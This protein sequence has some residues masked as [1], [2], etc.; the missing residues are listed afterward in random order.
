MRFSCLTHLSCT[1]CAATFEPT[2]LLN[3]CPAPG[4]GGSLFAEYDLPPLSRDDVAGRDRTIWRWHELMPARRPE[5]IV[6]LG[7][8]ERPSFTRP[9]SGRASG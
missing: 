6:T 4:C 1:K 8:G 5:E 9:G 3:V 7:E 2:R